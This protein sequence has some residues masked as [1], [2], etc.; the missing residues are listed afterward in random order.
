MICHLMDGFHVSLGNVPV[1]FRHRLREQ[2]NCSMVGHQPYAD[3]EGEDTNDA[4]SI[5]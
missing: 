5:R 4:K 2:S 3:P 1:E